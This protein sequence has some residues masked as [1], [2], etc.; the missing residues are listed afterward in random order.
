MIRRPPRSTLFPYTTLFR[1]PNDPLLYERLANFLEQNNLSAQEEQIYQQALAKFQD[2]SYY[3]KLARLYLRE[4]KR[5]A[6]SE[7]TTRVTGIF[8]GTDL[9][10]FFANVNRS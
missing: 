9:D 5:E 1:S 4:R 6:F 7:L 10:H 8:S 2:S 3:D